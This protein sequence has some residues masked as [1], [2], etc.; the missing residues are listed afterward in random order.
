M[1]ETKVLEGYELGDSLE[2]TV[3][4]QGMGGS[5]TEGTV[6]LQPQ[7]FYPN[8]FQGPLA[9]SGLPQS[10]IQVLIQVGN[11]TPTTLPQPQYVT[12]Q[13]VTHQPVMHPAYSQPQFAPQPQFSPQPQY[14]SYTAPPQYAPQ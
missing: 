9:L 4:D 13:P 12:H 6:K 7:Q 3:H 8:G 2:F 11:A 14:P 1:G 10:M 5:K